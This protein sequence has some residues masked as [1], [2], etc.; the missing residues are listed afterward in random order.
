VVRVMVPDVE[1]LIDTCIARRMQRLA[2]LE[3]R[4]RLTAEEGRVWLAE[5]SSRGARMCK[6]DEACDVEIVASEL[7]LRA[8]LARPREAVALLLL[9]KLRV[10]GDMG[11]IDALAELVEGDD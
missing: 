1:S 2:K 4:V 9:G 11:H 10:R 3:T 7:V 6:D 5:L 8:V